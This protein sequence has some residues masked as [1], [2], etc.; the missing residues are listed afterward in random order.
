MATKI[1]ENES[2]TDK[3]VFEMDNGD[4]R[5]LNE[6]VE[7]WHFKNQESAMRFALAVLKMTPPGELANKQ[8][9]L[10]PAIELTKPL[11]VHGV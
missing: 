1:R 5:A 10:V 3:L 9:S 6:V 11:E 8:Q 4:L 7:A 2:N